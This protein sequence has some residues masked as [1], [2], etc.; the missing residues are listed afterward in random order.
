MAVL[1]DVVNGSARFGHPKGMLLASQLFGLYSGFVYF[2]PVLG[3]LIADRWIGQR[4][5][6]V[7]G[8]LCL[9]TGHIAMTFD[10][11]SLVALTLLVMGAGFLKGNI[12]AQVGA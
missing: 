7:I 3:G 11:S 12:S 6:V 4:N 2:T 9:T 10:Q 5:A 1:T 8:T